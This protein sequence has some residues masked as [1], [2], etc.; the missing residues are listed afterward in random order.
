M[1]KVLVVQRIST[2]NG[3]NNY[4]PGRPRNIWF[5]N[6]YQQIPAKITPEEDFNKFSKIESLGLR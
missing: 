3:K 5:T 2:A 4:C 6:L 1:E